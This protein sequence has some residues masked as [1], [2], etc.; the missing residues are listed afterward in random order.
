MSEDF[1]TPEQIKERKERN[2][3]NS[4]N[5][6]YPKINRINNLNK[7]RFERVLLK[8]PLPHL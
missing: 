5:Y 1:P 4:M 6:W 7:Y 2:K 8:N 3:F